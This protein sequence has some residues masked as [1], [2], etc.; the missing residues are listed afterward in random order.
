MSSRRSHQNHHKRRPRG[1]RATLG[2]LRRVA[3]GRL[4][5]QGGDGRRGRVSSRQAMKV[6]SS[7]T[8]EHRDSARMVLVLTVGDD[9]FAIVAMSYSWYLFDG[10]A[11]YTN[12]IVWWLVH[13]ARV[14][15]KVIC[16]Q[17]S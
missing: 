11:W 17:G 15:S 10:F 13:Q 16:T 8:L 2:I 9:V 5:L 7:I 4:A 6:S 3:P 1:R 14:R 12:V